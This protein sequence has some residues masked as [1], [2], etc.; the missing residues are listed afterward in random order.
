MRNLKIIVI[1]GFV[2]YAALC[3]FCLTGFTKPNKVY[4]EIKNIEK[5]I[6]TKGDYKTSLTILNKIL[7][8]DP[9]DP[10][11]LYAAGLASYGLMEYDK[12]YESQRQSQRP[13]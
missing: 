9:D 10:Y 8:E 1:F 7:K 2:F 5:D 13:V 6:V 11:A 4:K 3:V 12:S